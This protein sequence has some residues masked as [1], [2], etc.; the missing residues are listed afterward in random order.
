M[1]PWID[2]YVSQAHWRLRLLAAVLQFT[3]A[4]RTGRISHRCGRR[5]GAKFVCKLFSKFSAGLKSE[6]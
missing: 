1:V 3:A 2:N 6:I 5:I 4:L